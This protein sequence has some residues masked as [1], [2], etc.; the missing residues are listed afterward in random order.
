MV[1]F[2]VGVMAAAFGF[3]MLNLWYATMDTLAD[4]RKM[5]VSV[6]YALDRVAYYDES[7]FS[8]EFDESESVNGQMN[9]S[10]NVTHFE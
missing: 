7:E 10:L 8:R 3:T 6:R 5:L 2:L 4:V 9:E 1:A